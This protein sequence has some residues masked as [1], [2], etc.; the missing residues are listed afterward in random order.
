MTDTAE[1]QIDELYNYVIILL[2]AGAGG[3]FDG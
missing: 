1:E 3:I 2:V